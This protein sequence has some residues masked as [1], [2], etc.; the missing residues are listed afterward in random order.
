MPAAIAP[1][2]CIVRFIQWGSRMGL[3]FVITS[4]PQLLSMHDTLVG[5]IAASALVS[6]IV[7]LF[8]FSVRG[9]AAHEPGLADLGSLTAALA[10]CL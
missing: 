4:P 9:M 5:L 8:G 7:F 1:I 10:P 6:S 3:E 2:H